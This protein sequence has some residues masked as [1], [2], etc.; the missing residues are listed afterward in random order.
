MSITNIQPAIAKLLDRERWYGERRTLHAILLDCGLETEVKWGKLCYSHQ[1]NNVA[2]IHATKDYFALGFFKGS[3]LEDAAGVLTSPGP[4]SQA[5]RQFRFEDVRAITG[6]EGLIREFVTM[7]IQLERD[8][9]KVDFAEKFNPI[10]PPELQDALD[11]DPN[12]AQAF[13]D[14]TPGRRRGYV[15]HIS[16]AKRSETRISRIAK[17]SPRILAGKGFNER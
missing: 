17:C 9:R 12:L 1:G 8:G 3:L 15:L 5:M 16:D 10:Y 14:L 2:I 13:N 4:H 6:K 7:A 11:N